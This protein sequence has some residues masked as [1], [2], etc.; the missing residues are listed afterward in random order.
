MSLTRALQPGLRP[1]QYTKI[2]LLKFTNISRNATLDII[3][4]S[5]IGEEPGLT[6]F[7]TRKLRARISE[8]KV[9]EQEPRSTFV[10]AEMTY[11]SQ[12]ISRNST[13]P[14]PTWA[15]KLETYTLRHHS[16]RETVT[17]EVSQAMRKA[18]DHYERL[19]IGTLEVDDSATCMM[20]LVLRQMFEAKKA[21]IAA[22]DPTKDPTMLDEGHDSTANTLAWFVKFMEAYPAVQTELRTTLKF[23]FPGPDPPKV[24]RI[25]NTEI[26]YLDG[27]LE[28]SLRLAGT[29]KGTVRQAL[30]DTDILG[31][32]IPKGAEVLLSLHI[33]QTPY[34]FNESKRSPGCRAAISKHGNR[35]SGAAE[36][37]LASFEPRR[38]L[39]KD[40][41]TGKETFNPYALPSL[42]FGGGYRGCFGRKLA[43]LEFR[44]V[45]V[46][47][48]LNLEF[49]E[50]PE[51]LRSMRASEKL[52]RRPEISFARIGVL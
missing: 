26:P 24:D 45:V 14:M 39:M 16:F 31:H 44:I 10:K 5:L 40:E 1:Q 38:W 13:T 15:Q 30:V 20:D 21:G 46:L 2:D 52:F 6:R 28:E 37:N 25:L 35:L 49:L 17:R 41:A 12:A 43:T 34:S 9:K 47:L 22:T 4:A 27:T 50:L 18:T 11:I 8:R 23:A 51:S 29:A 3:W 48:I 42:A 36:R 33:N 19:D 7:E 32:K